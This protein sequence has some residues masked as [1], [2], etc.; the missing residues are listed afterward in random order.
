MRASTNY[1]FLI[2]APFIATNIRSFVPFLLTGFLVLTT[3]C[4]APEALKAQDGIRLIIDTDA[5]NELDDQYALAYALFNESVF[6]LEGITVN[7]TSNGGD[8]DAHY[9][10]A[11]RILTLCGREEIPLFRGASGTYAEIAPALEADD[12]DGHEA[13]DFIIERA[14][15]GDARPLVLAPIGKLTNIALALEKDPSIASRV[16]ILWLGSNWPKPG[17]YNLVNDTSAVNPV[18]HSAAPFEMA[19]VR[20]NEFSGTSAVILHES[21]VN[22]RLPGLGI[23]ISDPITGRHGGAFYTFGDYAADLFEKMGDETR[24]LY[25]MA[26]LAVLKN[27]DWAEKASIDAPRL[28]S[29]TWRSAPRSDRTIAVW[30]NFNTSLI[31]KD[32]F[33]TL[34]QVTPR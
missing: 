15:A 21:E 14:H 24:A 10:E 12:F 9:D 32:F 30:E 34:H 11:A 25:D 2:R 1:S 20:Y 29:G 17:E 19:L 13:V 27:P 22:E 26:A 8:I 28:E 31:L 33:D 6:D 7:R 3:A 4:F 23:R 16:R 18:I 5:N